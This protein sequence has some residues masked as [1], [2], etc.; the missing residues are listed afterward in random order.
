MVV[1]VNMQ[2]LVEKRL[3]PQLFIQGG[4]RWRMLQDG[5]NRPMSLELISQVLHL[6]IRVLQQLAQL[7]DAV[8]Q[9]RIVHQHVLDEVRH[10]TGASTPQADLCRGTVRGCGQLA[11][12]GDAPLH[13]R[14]NLQV[15]FPLCS[16]LHLDAVY[17]VLKDRKSVV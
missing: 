9:I 5:R 13:A 14:H 10:D 11:I 12:H 8:L 16:G 15:L 1:V 6:F 4:R 17:L 2:L 7:Q 3:T